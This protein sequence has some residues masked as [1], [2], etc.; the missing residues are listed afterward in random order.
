[1]ETWA[2][3]SRPSRGGK[4]R[5]RDRAVVIVCIGIGWVECVDMGV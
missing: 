5:D 4:A 1:L 3:R 2:K